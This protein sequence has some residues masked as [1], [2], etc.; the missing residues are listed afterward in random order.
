VDKL[1]NSTKVYMEHGN[2]HKLKYGGHNGSRYKWG[3]NHDGDNSIGNSGWQL[4]DTDILV[5]ET[6]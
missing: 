5:I 3:Q 1:G 6:V 4:V 2:G